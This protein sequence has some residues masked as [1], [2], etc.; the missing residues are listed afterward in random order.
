M[1]VAYAL[2]ICGLATLFAFAKRR[3]YGRYPPGPRGLPIIG[4][5]LDIPNVN[6]WATYKEWSDTHGTN[7]VADVERCLF[8]SLTSTSGSDIVHMKLLNTHLYIV[9]TSEAAKKLFDG[10]SAIYSDRYVATNGS[11]INN[12]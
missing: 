3:Q 12:K 5:V 6:S 8:S 1:I 2:L 9:N 7:D 10:R 11:S 4:N